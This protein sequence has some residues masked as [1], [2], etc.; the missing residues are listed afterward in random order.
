MTGGPERKFGVNTRASQAYSKSVVLLTAALVMAA[1][2]GVG[3]TGWTQNINILTLVG[4]GVIVIGFLLARSLLPGVVAHLFS[5]IIGVGWAFWVTSRLLPHDYTWPERWTNL[6]RRLYNWYQ[7]A[8]QGGTSYDNL[9]FV[10]QM[11]VI[12]WGMGYLTIWFMARSGKPW[13]AIVPGGMVLLINLYYAP[14]DITWWFIAYILIGLLLVIRFNLLVQEREWRREGVFFRPDISF[15]FLRDGMILSMLVLF[16]AWLTPPL[17]NTQSLQF[18]DNFHGSWRDIQDD[19]NRMFADLNYR[20]RIAY[21]SFGTSLRLGGARQLSDDPVMAV[22]VEGPGRYWRAVTF[23]YYTGD[24]WLSRDESSAPFGEGALPTLPLFQ[25]RQPVTQTYTYYHDNALVIYAMANA[26]D[27]DRT[28]R[29]NFNPVPAEQAAQAGVGWTGEAEPWAEALTYIRSNA[30]VD[31][32]ESYRVVSLASRAA[33]EQLRRAGSAYPEWITSRY[34]NLPPSITERTKALAQEITA[35][36]DND[37]DKAQAV[38]KYLR[39]NIKYNERIST[40]PPGIDKVDYIVFTSREGYCDYYATAMIV[41]LRSLGIPARLAA[42]FAQGDFDPE[43]GVYLVRN[44]DAHSWVEVYFPRYGWIDFEPTAAQPFITRL[45]TDQTMPN[46]AALPPPP[47]TPVDE[48][49]NI[50]IDEDVVLG[51]ASAWNLQLPF[52]NVPIRIPF[53]VMGGGL[54]GLGLMLLLGG[55]AGVVWWRQLQSPT[56]GNESV[57]SLY[58]HMVRLS[59]WLGVSLRPWQTP[60]E[61]AAA[62]QRHLPEQQEAVSAITGEYVHQVYRNPHQVDTADPAPVQAANRAWQQLRPAMLKQSLRR[63]LPRWLRL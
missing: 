43:T 47:P 40:P 32:D 22:R 20:D 16:F 54:A 21:D 59:T 33:M 11:G 57:F 58:Q 36:F 8:L 35:P 12:V 49:N 52:W 3:A 31:V 48:R 7:I 25:M 28:A 4:L 26:I 51:D 42:G 50:P 53:V 55:A 56:P 29:A 60:Y 24:G 23:D 45:T 34:L 15:D 14:R 37:F 62:L 18:L 30:T 46:T 5:L 19:W 38:E 1:T 13:P 27:L 6:S 2:W 41:M 17:V 10:L 63:R 39:A 44:R 9:M 61:H